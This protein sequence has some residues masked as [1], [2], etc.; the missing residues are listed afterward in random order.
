MSNNNEIEIN[1]NVPDKDER[2]RLRKKR[3]DK[4]NTNDASNTEEAADKEKDLTKTGAQQVSDSL[5]NLDRRKHTGLQAVTAI[6]VNT[7]SLETKRRIDEEE[8][9]KERLRKLQYEAVGSAKANAAIDMKWAELMERDIPQ[10][11]HHDIQSQMSSCS[12]ALRGKDELIG[13]FQRQLRAK[14]EEY[15][16]TLRKQAEDIEELLV[17][18]RREFN[19]LQVEYDKEIDAI[20]E[21]YLEERERIINEHTSELEA[22][23]EHR[24]N[25]ET[26]YKDT[27]AK[28]EEQFQRDIEEL[29]TK[30]ADQYN[31]VKIELEMNIQTL[32]QQL[33]EIRATYQLNTEKLDYNYRVLTEFDVEKRIE[34]TR[35]KRRLGNLKEQ[36]NQ[37]VSKYT[38][39]E[40]ADSKMNNELTND[41]RSLTRKYKEL[42]AK[43]R[44]F[45]VA[46]TSKYDEMWA[47]HEDEAKDMVDQLLKADKIITEQQL[48][49]SFK[50][51]D[52]LALQT[53]LGRQGNLGAAQPPQDQ[54]EKGPENTEIDDNNN[55]GKVSGVRIRA[56]LRL[57]AQEAGF[58]INPTIQ[59]MIA[60]MPDKEADLAKAETLLKALGVKS[61]QALHNLVTYF[62][63]DTFLRPLTAQAVPDSHEDLE[64]D[65]L[66]LNPPEDLL[67]LKE[68]IRSEDVISAIKVYMED[69][70]VEGNGATGPVAGTAKAKEE[71]ERIR[72]RRLQNIQNYWTQLSQVVSD[73]TVDVWRQLEQ[74][75]TVMR[76]LL[77]KRSAAV[78]D[79]DYQLNRNTELKRLLNQYLG[80]QKMNGALQIPPASVMKV[81]DVSKTIKLS[82]NGK[83]D[84]LMSKTK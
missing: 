10:E 24:R 22:M 39:L 20:E 32:K 83:K 81:R 14:D 67:E 11:L 45:E 60:D 56:V 31:K 18:I 21:S 48:G 23:F 6:R 66:L 15:V 40:S 74:N 33:E 70:S 52:L 37:L 4:R 36:L 17:R 25:K 50:P 84:V 19:E 71:E 7:D 62:F 28:R 42:Q 47:M 72:Q 61:E 68:I 82:K 65:L 63:K 27:K 12:N 73:S 76:E 55:E 51:P 13:E 41:Y 9:R 1:T 80:D 79:V 30:G 54:P 77:L 69:I 64:N 53:A 59:S 16:R 26:F 34:L 38:E 35:Y 78:A 49:W 58:L 8:L 57:L 2:K 43:F 5:F 44:H 3:I 46:D 75:S 29:I